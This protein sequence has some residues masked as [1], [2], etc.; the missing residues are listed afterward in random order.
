VAR[1]RLT[2]LAA[3]ATQAVV[4]LLLFVPDSRPRGWVVLPLSLA[5]AAVLFLPGDLVRRRIGATASGWERL[6]VG[7]GLSMVLV[8]VLTI[9]S[10]EAHLDARR[11]AI[12]LVAFSAAMAVW[13]LRAPPPGPA[14]SPNPPGPA[15][16]AGAALAALLLLVVLFLGVGGTVSPVSLA[17]LN[18]EALHVAIVRKLA[19]NETL[20]TTNVMY[21]PGLANTYVYPAYHF[22]LALVSRLSALDTLVVFVKARPFLVLLSLTALRS[23][24]GLLFGNVVADLALLSWVALIANNAAGL[25]PGGAYFWAQLAPLTHLGDFGLGVLFPLL[26][27][28]SLRFLQAAPRSPDLFASPCV[29]AAGLLVHTREVLQLLVFL[30]AAAIGVAVLRRRDRRILARLAALIL[31]TI[32]LGLAYKARHRSAAEHAL[33]FEAANLKLVA[34][35]MGPSLR[36]P[37]P[38]A[39][40]DV[41]EGRY[42]LMHRPFFLLPLA[43]LPAIWV[44][45]RRFWAVFLGSALLA[46]VLVIRI[47]QLSWAFVRLSYSEMLYTPSRYLFHAS[48]LLLGAALGAL[49]LLAERAFDAALGGFRVSVRREGSTTPALEIGWRPVAHR[50]AAAVILLAAS[51]IVGVVIAWSIAALGP[52]SADHLDWLYVNAIVGSAASLAVLTLRQRNDQPETDV[53]DREVRR[54]GIALLAALG[55]ILPLWR[56]RVP[57]DLPAQHAAWAQ[58][59]SMGDFWA[60]YDSTALGR[61]MPSV[62]VRFVRE[63]V[64]PR[65]VWAAPYAYIF[66][67]PVVANQY[68]ISSGYTLSTDFDFAGPYLRATGRRPPGES[69][70]AMP[71]GPGSTKAADWALAQAPIFNPSETARETLALLE[72]YGVDYVLTG[73]TEVDRFEALAHRFPAALERVYRSNRYGIFA[74]HRGALAGESRRAGS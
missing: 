39:V 69:G 50:T 3:L 59:R 53:P 32:G 29:V 10:L 45:R 68:V 2:P 31:I 40:L 57:P 22:A 54:P 12:A 27:L 37:W 44:F 34:D 56:L 7:A 67:I 24:A 18:E 62:V 25:I 65:R 66:Q 51:G 23:I 72:E 42:G 8:G 20:S 55:L 47:P 70:A 49:A 28:F 30:G 13:E 5:F 14:P 64:D 16:L 61:K 11:A 48:Y 19:E 71:A 74:V 33:A 15:L 41:D 1:E 43:V 6:P 26:L 73:P 21:K 35:A 38:A 17:A 63:R 9:V 36:Q 4:A 52:L 58:Q 46:A 60:W